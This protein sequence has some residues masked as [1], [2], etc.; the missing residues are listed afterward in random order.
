MT[1]DLAIETEQGMG[2][3]TTWTKYPFICAKI[4]PDLPDCDSNLLQQR[5]CLSIPVRG[6][7]NE[8]IREYFLHVHPNLP[9]I[10]EAD[11]WDTYMNGRPEPIPLMLFQAMLF[12]ACSFVG[13]ACIKRL[14]FKSLR[15]ARLAFYTRAKTLYDFEIHSG[16]VCCAQT[17]LLLTYYVSQR[18]PKTN[19]YWLTIALHHARVI[20]AHRY[21]EMRHYEKANLLKRI[22]WG[23]VCRDRLLSLGLRRPF[24]I[25]APDFDF[26]QSP[27]TVSDFSDEIHR[28]LVYSADTKR[29][30]IQLLYFQCELCVALTAG[31]TL[32][33]PLTAAAIVDQDNLIHGIDELVKWHEHTK[34]QLNY[35]TDWRTEHD[36]TVL[37]RNL[38]LIY[39]YSAQLA[40]KNHALYLAMTSHPESKLGQRHLLGYLPIT[41]AANIALPLA[42]YMIGTQVSCMEMVGAPNHPPQMIYSRAFKI[43]QMQYEGTDQ[44]LDYIQT[45]IHQLRFEAGSAGGKASRARLTSRSPPQS[46]PNLQSRTTTAAQGESVMIYSFAHCSPDE[47]VRISK[48]IDVS[49][50]IGRFPERTDL[51]TALQSLKPT[52]D[53]RLC[54]SLVFPGPGIQTL[55]STRTHTAS[56]S[57]SELDGINIETLLS[58]YNEWDNAAFEQDGGMSDSMPIEDSDATLVQRTT[59]EPFSAVEAFGMFSAASSA[60]DLDS[61]FP[62]GSTVDGADVTGDETMSSLFSYD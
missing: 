50:A 33:S 39:Y 31:L 42:W 53:T 34:V 48:T 21:Y 26:T 15:A 47:Y 44:V 11:F 37:Y 57:K 56:P 54:R 25:S 8:L 17:A 61:L 43:L 2:P 36:S 18:N 60:G 10:N 59:P 62:L 28:S 9:V 16:D 22:W 20:H 3:F 27:L 46:L 14:G 1:G 5:G 32:L 19:S 52:I 49:L 38:L 4:D 40:L 51:P 13:H 29:V 55:T 24:Q 7:L 45:I 41:I 6:P 30:L 12:A 23:C 58:T 35:L